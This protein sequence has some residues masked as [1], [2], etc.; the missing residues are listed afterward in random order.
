MQD[1]TVHLEEWQET[2]LTDVARRL[3][4][5]K[6]AAAEWLLANQLLA[7]RTRSRVAGVLSGNDAI[8]HRLGS[9]FA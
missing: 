6:E 1:L 9:L 7:T 3:G 4:I 8:E 2:L 5:G